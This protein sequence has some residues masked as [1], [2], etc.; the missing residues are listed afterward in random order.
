MIIPLDRKRLP[1]ACN[2]RPPPSQPTGRQSRN[3][4]PPGT[5]QLRTWPAGLYVTLRR[6]CL[7]AVGSVSQFPHALEQFIPTNAQCYHPHFQ[8]KNISFSR[9]VLTDVSQL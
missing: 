4:V 7:F 3:G 9:W 1:G 2:A 5:A 8:A 6:I